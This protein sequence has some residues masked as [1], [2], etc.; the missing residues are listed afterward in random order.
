MKIIQS[1]AEG[2]RPSLDE[3]NEA[4][5]QRYPLLLKFKD[6]PQEP[7]WH[8]EGDVHI[9]TQMVLDAAYDLLEEIKLSDSDKIIVI[10]SCLFHDI[11][12]P[13]V[14]VQKDNDGIMRWRSPK[15]A[16][17]GRSI[18]AYDLFDLGLDLYQIH[19]IINII[20]HHQNLRRYVQ[21][22]ETYLFHQLRREVD[23]HLLHIVGKADLI[24]RVCAD[25][26]SQ[27]DITETFL[28]MCDEFMP[29]RKAPQLAWRE[30]FDK[31]ECSEE[32]KD[33]VFYRSMHEYEKGNMYSAEEA[34]GRCRAYLDDPTELVILC[35]PS[36]SG[37][38]TWVRNHPEYHVVSMDNLRESIAKNKHD[39]SKNGKVF[40]AAK[41]AVKDN[42]RNKRKMVWDNT[43]LSKDKRKILV[44]LGMDY[45][46][47]VRIVVMQSSKADIIKGNSDR[48]FPV[49]NDIMDRQL[50]RGDFPWPREAH[51]VDYVHKDEV[52]TF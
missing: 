49:P 18:L 33:E 40:Q 41:E 21:K 43:S 23:V 12:K 50:N 8:G 14:T 35:G 17:V 29:D 25:K 39:Q 7:E 15:H 32:K 37:K 13:I 16:E 48:E 2:K 1:I 9:H 26:A 51:R 11:A 5:G 47:Y 3:F 36:G 27:I 34:M 45:G 30:E 19:Q 6:T 20:G 46:A 28:Y 38:S 44:D 52:I 42:L 4:L 24:G 10:L 22:T 31:L